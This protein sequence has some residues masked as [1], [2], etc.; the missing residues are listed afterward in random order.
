VK[1]GLHHISKA[2]HET[3]AKDAA[4]ETQVKANPTLT[5]A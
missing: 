3:A 2:G 5:E 4:E 1:P